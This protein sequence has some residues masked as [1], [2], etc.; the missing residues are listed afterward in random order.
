MAQNT[1]MGAISGLLGLWLSTAAGTAAGSTEPPERP[2]L[3]LQAA[4]EQ[5]LGKNP[6]IRVA[7]RRVELELGAHQEASGPFDPKIDFLVTFDRRR[8]ELLLIQIEFEE[9]RRDIHRTL[10]AEFTRIIEDLESKLRD[11][12]QLPIPDCGSFILV[13]NGIDVCLS[14]L[15][16][17]QAENLDDLLEQLGGN[18]GNIRDR[19]RDLLRQ[20]ALNVILEL[21]RQI[22]S[23]EEALRRLGAVP[24]VEEQY[25]LT[26]DLRLRKALRNGLELAVGFILQGFQD[27]YDGKPLLGSFGGKGIPNAFT[28]FA[29]FSLDVPLGKNRGRAAAGAPEQAAELRREAAELEFV[30][31]SAASALATVEAYWNLVGAQERSR[32]LAQAVI[33]EEGLRGPAEQLADAGE[34]LTRPDLDRLA[35]RLAST[36]ESQKRAQ[37]D[38][39]T[40]RAVLADAIGLEVDSRTS[41][42]AA[43]EEGL[44]SPDPAILGELGAQEL[45]R[46]AVANRHDL[47]ARRTLDEA[48]R[49]LLR[50]ADRNLSRRVDLSLS[51]GYSGLFE[52]FEDKVY[53]PGAVFEPLLGSQRGPSVLFSLKVDFPSGNR[54]ARAQLE[55]ARSLRRQS[56]IGTTDLERTLGL[57]VTELC[58]AV[59]AAAGEASRQREAVGYYRETLKLTL[60]LFEAG[61]T[62]LVDT[63]LTEER[64]TFAELDHVEAR[65]AYALLF[66]RLKFETGSL[67]DDRPGAG[68]EAVLSLLPMDELGI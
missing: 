66:A 4:V 55:Q 2:A 44:P 49:V 43:S 21:R 18:A 50:A 37:R 53:D 8:S 46:A 54:A 42:P 33:R 32:L 34:F 22:A 1:R 17:S 67:L 52:S 29:G 11:E 47:R 63:I 36:R 30:H 64:L 13:I 41:L 48:S 5:T 57:R 68:G 27:N 65:L 51:A 61:E 39:L 56:A 58:N 24:E 6:S 35:A 38:V 3:T 26:I 16:R 9:G 10:I 15:A 31:R 60:A 59:V 40:A 12:D 62:N 19:Q 25:E 45:G 23:S 7:R 14:D 20:L 28:S